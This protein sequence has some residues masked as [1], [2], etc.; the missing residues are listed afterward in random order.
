M[1]VLLFKVV[2]LFCLLKINY[3]YSVLILLILIFEV[4]L[5][6]IAG[7]VKYFY[8]ALKTSFCNIQPF[9]KFLF[10]GKSIK[11]LKLEVPLFC[12]FYKN[13]IS[14][15][16]FSV[17]FVSFV[18]IVSILKNLFFASYQYFLICHGKSTKKIKNRKCYKNQ[19][20]NVCQLKLFLRE[21]NHLLVLIWTPTHLIYKMIYRFHLKLSNLQKHPPI[22]HPDNIPNGNNCEHIKNSKYLNVSIIEISE[23]NHTKYIDFSKTLFE[24]SSQSSSSKWYKEL[25]WL[26][27]NLDKDTAFCYTCMSAE[28]KRLKTIYHYNKDETLITRGYRD[29]HHAAENFQSE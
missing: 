23:K 6:L 7:N 21:I 25:P 27:Y 4:K 2:Q 13:K 3:T 26:H 19:V 29:Q 15:I 9:L 20:K 1:N 24:K 28:K 17:C 18:S 5:S 11:L 14:G 22:A 12:N 10:R 16:W 8:F